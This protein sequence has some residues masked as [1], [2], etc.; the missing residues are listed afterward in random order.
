MTN[1]GTGLAFAGHPWRA[2]A[3]Q[4]KHFAAEIKKMV[5]A[6]YANAGPCR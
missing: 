2:N 5:S 1:I 4:V 6:R 3:Q